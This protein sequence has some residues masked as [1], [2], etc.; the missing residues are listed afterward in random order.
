[1]LLTVSLF[2]LFLSFVVLK[3]N[4][5]GNKTAVYLSFFLQITAIYGITHYLILYS[6]SAFWIA[7]FYNHFT[8]LMLLLGPLLYFYVRGVIND[9]SSLTKKD[10][11]HFIPALIHGIGLIPYLI[12]P[13]E[14]KIKIANSI[15]LNIDVLTQINVNYWYSAGT[16]FL[17]RPI[18]LLIYAIV[19]CY[20]VWTNY[21]VKT[22]DKDIPKKQL[23]FSY[24]WIVILLT[25]VIL[26]TL[27]FL[28]ITV[29]SLS[30]KPSIGLEK[31]YSLY[32]VMGLA[33]CSISFFLLLFPT[34]LY[35]IPRRLKNRRLFENNENQIN[36]KWEKDT[37]TNEPFAEIAQQI[38]EYIKTE[39]P[40][41]DPSFSI[42]DIS[43]ALKIPQNHVS[44]C[45]H[46]ILN[47][48]FPKLKSE[49]R[50]QYAI[51]LLE[52]NSKEVLT[53][54]AIGEKSG[55]K[56]RSNF[57]TTFKDLTGVTPSEYIENQ[58]KKGVHFDQ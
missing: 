22:E 54:E 9:T 33:F 56:T 46:E 5:S 57:Y 41:V 13:F 30:S 51:D 15:I 17:T 34:I 50:V 40:F 48:R 25:T 39:K 37:A 3:N 26:L 38:L 1:M 4:W 49:L 27:G 2:T 44:Y 20:L 23:A 42:S 45:I 19:S 52:S 43:F 47:T 55:F 24:R 10:L 58:K 53:I 21:K 35:G 14:E 16:S 8:A 6:Q 29:S 32:L 7:I 28:Y 36:Y 31:S 12:L 18:H 11:L